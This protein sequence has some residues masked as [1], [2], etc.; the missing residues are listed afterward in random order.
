MIINFLDKETEKIYNQ[1]FTKKLPTEIQNIALRKLLMI[2]SANSIGDLYSPPSNHL[3]KLKGTINTWSIR[4][5][6][7]WRICFVP[8][9]NGQDFIDVGIVDYH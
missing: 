3:E 5:N 6:D 4:I 7:Q 8:I 9:N 1:T 2:A